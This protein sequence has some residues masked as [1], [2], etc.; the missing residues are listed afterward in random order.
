MVLHMTSLYNTST[1]IYSTEIKLLFASFFILSII[2]AF[3]SNFSLL[4]FVYLTLCIA[5]IYYGDFRTLVFFTFCNIFQNIFLIIF[6]PTLSPIESQLFILFKELIIYLC[7]FRY[8]LKKITYKSYEKNQINKFCNILL[9][10]MCLMIAIN[11]LTP[12]APIGAR[13][14]AMR[15]I[16]LMPL[17]YF[18]GLSLTL[19]PHCLKKYYL[20]FIRLMQIICIS[21][22]IIYY[23][24]DTFWIN[25]NLFTYIQNKSGIMLLEL[26]ESFYSYDLGSRM[27]RL[28]SIIAEPV[29]TSH[30]IGLACILIFITFKKKFKGT[31]LLFITCAL[32]CIS[33][34]L[35]FFSFC[36]IAIYIYVHLKNKKLRFIFLTS[37]LF[38][39]IICI[40][41]LINHFSGMEGNTATGNHLLAF[42]Y[43]INNATLIGNGIGTAGFNVASMNEGAD[44]GYTESFFAVLVA[45]IGSIGTGTFYLFLFLKG[46]YFI[47]EYRKKNNPY[48]LSAIIILLSVTFESFISGS[49]I[50]M[51]GTSLYFIIPGII[52][53]NIYKLN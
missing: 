33:K 17:C 39:L 36:S 5:V 43:G 14:T 21:G 2:C 49:A 48:L 29:A 30:L 50:S 6:S 51:I 3:I 18:F 46:I 12:N 31:K 9:I 42:V 52:E 7:T 40:I 37:S 19:S 16:I 32:L 24:P 35:L 26:P 53:R 22:L 38:L 41:F 8:L 13:I 34:T 27:K 15:Q 25:I 44:L 23:L 45:Q 28:V 4:L 11:M 1:K 47:Q 10:F 20:L